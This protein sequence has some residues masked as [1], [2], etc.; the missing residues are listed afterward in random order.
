MKL[1]SI[2]EENLINLRVIIFPNEPDISSV[3]VEDVKL[4]LPPPVL[5]GNTKRLQEYHKFEI[6]FSNFSMH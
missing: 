4:I 6:K 2:F 1:K 3:P 5:L